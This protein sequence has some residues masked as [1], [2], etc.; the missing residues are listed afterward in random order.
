MQKPSWALPIA[1][2]SA[3][4]P[5]SAAAKS[6]ASAATTTALSRGSRFVHH[7]IPPHEVVAIQRLDRALGFFVAIDFD[8][9]EAARL[10]RETVA[11]Q[12]DAG[13][14][15]ACLREP[16][17]QFLFAGLKRQI[18]HVEFFHRPTPFPGL[19]KRQER[20]ASQAL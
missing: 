4:A 9:A 18:T 2:P 14:R 11:Y 5:A 3:T 13:H 15:H 12:R 1:P 7:D 17:A 6:V 16:A 8:K 10:T 19:L 20:S